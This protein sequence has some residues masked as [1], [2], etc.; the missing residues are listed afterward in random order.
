MI[1][2]NKLSESVRSVQVRFSVVVVLHF[3]EEIVFVLKRAESKAVFA[4]I[5]TLPGL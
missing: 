5:E 4:I 2:S 1:S 3:A